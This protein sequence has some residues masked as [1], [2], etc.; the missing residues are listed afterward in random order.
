MICG[1]DVHHASKKESILGFAASMDAKVCQF[2]TSVLRQSE[3]QEIGLQMEKAIIT[4]AANFNEAAGTWPQRIIVY[5]DGVSFSQMQAILSHEVAQV[6]SGLKSLDV[7]PELIYVIV[8][9]RV[10]ARFFK[11][12]KGGQ[13]F[14]PDRGTIIDTDV[15][16]QDIFDFYLVS[17]GSRVGVQAPTHYHV[18]YWSNEVDVHELY[19][20]TYRLTYGYYNFSSSIKVPS[21]VIYAH[22]LSKLIGE[23]QAK[24]KGTE[25]QVNS[26]LSDKL[27]FI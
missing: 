27:Y 7:Q 13:I 20:L 25:I 5:R 3:G 8:N 18:A 11:S 21:P 23:T 15:V 10:N 2:H 22:K 12:D 6:R 26:K 14:N 24:D 1:V 19:E 4:A 16:N 9:K 17:H